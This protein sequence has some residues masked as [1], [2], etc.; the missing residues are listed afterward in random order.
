VSLNNQADL[1]VGG[2][3]EG[4]HFAGTLEFLRICLGTLADAGTSIEELHAWQFDGPFRR[5]FTGKPRRSED[6]CAGALE[7]R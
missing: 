2:T 7:G 4:R 1:H 6:G 5:D 3:P